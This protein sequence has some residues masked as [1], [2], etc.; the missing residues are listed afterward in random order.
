MPMVPPGFVALVI[1]L[2]AAFIPAP[3]YAAACPSPSEP[4]VACTE[5]GAVRGVRE[6]NTLA[7]KGIPYAKPPVGSLRWRPPEEGVRWEGIRNASDFGAICPQIVGGQVVGSEDCLTLNVWRARELP[8]TPL[9][10]MIWLTG[11]GNHALSGKGSAIF[12]GVSYDGE[13][14]VERGGVVYVSYNLRLGVLGFL[15]HPALDTE[16]PE[17]VSGNY[18]SLDQIAMLRWVRRNIAAFGGDPNRVFLFGT[19]AGGGNICALMTSPLARGLFPRGGDAEQ[20]AD[21]LRDPDTHRRPE[22]NRR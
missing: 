9:P 5:P 21:R 16:R 10:V 20:C 11:G 19:S 6:G 14:L 22:G 18:G 13:T 7:F 12:G 4:D 15:A 2:A 17:R 8:A 1:L 3:T